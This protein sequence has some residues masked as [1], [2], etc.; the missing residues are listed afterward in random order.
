MNKVLNKDIKSPSDAKFARWQALFSNFDFSVEHIKG[1]INSIP[2][3]LSKEHLQA[4]CMIISVQLRNGAETLVN[5]PDSLNWEAYES[6]W[7]PHWELRSTKILIQTIHLAYSN[8]VPEIRNKRIS[9]VFA[10]IITRASQNAVE[11]Q[12]ALTKN[13]HDI[14]LIWDIRDNLGNNQQ[15]NVKKNKN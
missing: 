8:L 15:Y 12:E 6:E 3:F 4:S 10:P 2:D 11:A 7:R 5:I 9:N 14:D 1:T 13:F